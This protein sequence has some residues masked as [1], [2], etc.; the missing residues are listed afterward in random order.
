M[1][2]GGQELLHYDMSIAL[3]VSSVSILRLA[4]IPC[5]V[6]IL[7]LCLHRIMSLISLSMLVRIERLP[8]D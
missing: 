3:A 5:Q 8:A 1:L 2:D 7:P 4:G 6:L